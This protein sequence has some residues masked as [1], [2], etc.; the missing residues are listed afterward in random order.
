M[1]LMTSNIEMRGGVSFVFLM[2]VIFS[3]VIS[4]MFTALVVGG[5]LETKPQFHGY[6]PRASFAVFPQEI[7]RGYN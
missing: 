3:F 2:V 4:K 6:R 1:I 7:S 5:S